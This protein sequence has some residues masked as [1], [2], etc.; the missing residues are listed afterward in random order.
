[1]EVYNSLQKQRCKI[2][3]SF[4]NIW[5]MKPGEFTN[6]GKGI[7]VCSSLDDIVMRLKGK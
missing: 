2:G 1:M 6:R 7:S 5:I 3:N 4:K